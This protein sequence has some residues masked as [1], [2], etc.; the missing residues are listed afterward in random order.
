MD[1]LKSKKEENFSKWYHEIIEATHIVDS[2]VV[3][4]SIV[5]SDYCL[6]IWDQI[7]KFLNEKLSS[8]GF[9]EY[10]F[11]TLIPLSSF[12]KEKRHFE[13]FFRET[14]IVSKAGQN[15]L[16]E[17]MVIRPTS[18][19]IMYESFA[20]WVKA[21]EDL[22]LLVNQYCSVFRWESLKPNMPLIRGNEFLWQESHS[23]HKTEEE[24]DSFVKSLLKIYL[25]LSNDYAAMPVVQGFKPHHRMFPG[26]KYTLALEA[27]MPDLKSVQLATS[28]SLGQNFSSAFGIKFRDANG[29][30]KAAWQACNGITT[31]LI[32][33]MIMLH[34]DN[35]G[36]VLPS[37]LAP[38]Q[39]ILIGADESIKK[40][41]EE[42]GIR[43]FIDKSG[44][45]KDEKI[46]YWKMMGAP[47]I[48][49]KDKEKYEIIRRDTLE[50]KIIG[51]NK[52]ADEV[53]KMLDS[54]QKS[55]FEK[56][57][58]FNK[59]FAS[60]ADSWEEFEAAA[61]KGGFITAKWCGEV[62][63]AKQ[64]RETTKN[65]LRVVNPVKNGRC[66]H[67]SKEVHYEGIFA[68]AY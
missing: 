19:S 17:D 42:N 65:S 60:Q 53:P 63:C 21:E 16:K 64:I 2:T 13:D 66:V 23:A 18:E 25:E 24:A 59:K 15:A 10:Y 41:L 58:A 9:R 37:R 27:F 54:I 39:C 34:S 6:A 49:V 40:S 12:R 52:L 68:P 11:P 67:C 5:Y 61:K 30:E 51:Q 55:L 22:P 20:K 50:R 46:R 36:L 3:Q 1:I 47:V 8:M 14:L 44:K 35:Y 29:K 33:A 31:R 26:A 32:G 62:P 45:A 38:Y 28:H 48:A 4:G 43:C 57:K 56:A 7:K